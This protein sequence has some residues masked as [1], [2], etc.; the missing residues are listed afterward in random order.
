MANAYADLGTWW[1]ITPFIGAGIGTARVTIANFTD[2]GQTTNGGPSSAYADTASKWNF[3]WAVHAGLAYQ[4]N[5]NV[6]LELAYRYLNMGD[7]VTGDIV[8]YTGTNRDQQSD[9]VQGSHLRTDVEAWRALGDRSGPGLCAP[10]PPPLIRKGLIPA[11]S[12]SEDFTARHRPRRF[13]LCAERRGKR[14]VK[15]NAASSNIVK[16]RLTGKSSC[17]VGSWWR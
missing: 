17:C 3:A 7:G 12:F 10:M 4:V 11:S 6:T 9:H 8:T 14:L 16:R 13:L 1:C 5:P 15:V 2:V